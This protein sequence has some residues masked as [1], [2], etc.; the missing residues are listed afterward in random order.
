[1][2]SQKIIVWVLKNLKFACTKICGYSK[3]VG[4]CTQNLFCGYSNL[5]VFKICQC[6]KVIDTQICGTKICGY[7][8]F[9]STQK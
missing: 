1:M 9:V 3:F 2:A 5:W 8:K 7:S 4:M 6:S